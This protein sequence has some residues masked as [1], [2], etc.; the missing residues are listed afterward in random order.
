[1]TRM[2]SFATNF[3]GDIARWPISSVVSMNG[4]FEAASSFNQDLSG[5]IVSSIE[6][7]PDDFDAHATSW[8]PSDPEQ[9]RP[10]WGC[11]PQLQVSDTWD[12][13]AM[14]S[15]L[16]TEFV[17]GAPVTIDGDPPATS[18]KEHLYVLG[19]HRSAIGTVQFL[20]RFDDNKSPANFFVDSNTGRM[21]YSPI[22]E[23]LI[24]P[25]STMQQ[26]ISY[27]ASLLGTSA[28]A[29]V[30]GTVTVVQWTFTVRLPIPFRIKN[31]RHYVPAGRHVSEFEFQPGD[32]ASNTAACSPDLCI[33]QPRLDHTVLYYAQR[34]VTLDEGTFTQL[35]AY[36][37]IA[38]KMPPITLNG[39]DVEG[40]GA[41]D[42]ITD[43][44]VAYTLKGAPTG[45]FV[46]TS[47]AEVLGKPLTT[48]TFTA[49]IYALCGPSSV[50]LETIE[51]IVVEQDTSIPSNGPNGLPCVNGVSTDGV[52]FDSNF[53]C[54]CTLRADGSAASF[55]LPDLG[56]IFFGFCDP[57][58]YAH[59]LSKIVHR[60][61]HSIHRHQL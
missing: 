38:I 36:R 61:R 43:R 60:L 5:W 20:L 6:I 50:L 16:P 52:K 25:T 7:E 26:G 10:C 59:P 55:L 2:F 37:D 23:D 39:S 21:S 13:A 40:E 41:H 12:T 32:P 15:W 1:M 8:F 31:F 22:E 4:M 17:V 57:R 44:H 51:F 24:T 28:T 53:T 47:T 46:E 54:D 9:F 35:L 14:L 19:L 27:S 58:A 56:L 30:A 48:G 29:A 11:L 45:F 3:N 18:V 42:C 34:N 49:M 33:R